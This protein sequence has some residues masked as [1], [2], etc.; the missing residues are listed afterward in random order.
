MS[1]DCPLASRRQFLRDAG[2]AVAAL[3]A[4]GASATEA[5]AVPVH[6]ALAGSERA[7]AQ[8]KSYSIPDADAVVI[9]SQESVI[10][11]RWQGS[12]Y[13]L[14]LACP[15]QNTALRWEAGDHQFRC[16][17]HHSLFQP[18]GT[19]IEGRATRSMDRFAIRRDGPNV[20]VDLDKMYQQDTD[21]PAWMAA[22]V[23]M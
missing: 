16:P 2:T 17:K 1:C 21:G 3:M 23:K 5:M 4:L 7:A 8:Q 6:A 12:V 14:S 20:I 19:R 18:D 13:A 11:A 22:V 15:H 9:D 10:I